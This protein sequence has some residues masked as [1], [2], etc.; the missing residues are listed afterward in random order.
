MGFLERMRMASKRAAKARPNGTALRRRGEAAIGMSALALS[1][2]GIALCL[3]ACAPAPAHSPAGGIPRPSADAWLP[4]GRA[5]FA[6]DFARARV[7]KASL[8][9]GPED[10]LGSCRLLDSAR[11]GFPHPE[12][13]LALPAPIRPFAPMQAAWG[14]SGDFFLLDRAGPRLMLYDSN[15]QFLSGV[16]L[17][18][19]IR[20]RNLDAFQ[21]F[22]SRDGSFLFVDL[23]EGV[24]RQYAELRSYS[25]QGD[26]RLRN[27]VRLPV[28]TGACVWE[29]FLRNPCCLSAGGPPVC[30]DAYFNPMGRWAPPGPDAGP[31]FRALPSADGL[32]WQIALVG[33]PGCAAAPVCFAPGK[34][35]AACVPGTSPR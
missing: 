18:P 7:Q 32:E 5:L 15:A 11:A 25:D 20:G 23:G 13:W 10:T 4:A 27:T 33:G 31:G 29:P 35:P 24:V 19:E 21:V 6:F 14:P 16:G 12:G 2:A 1:A 8:A 26:W 22:R 28:G 9:R 30:F 17:P 3:A 34:A